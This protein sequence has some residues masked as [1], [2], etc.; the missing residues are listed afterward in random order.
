MIE[1]IS[2]QH[3]PGL[4]Q[5]NLKRYVKLALDTGAS[6][7]AIVPTGQIVVDER[8]LMK[9]RFPLCSEY[10]ACMN[11]PPN[12][13]SIDEMRERIKLFE[14]VIVLKMD[15]SGE[16]VA[17]PAARDEGVEDLKSFVKLSAI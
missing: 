7:A 2:L 5:Q 12:T 3:D 10:G 11:C 8:V 9:C 15:V 14:Y 1:K 16:R 4:L 13:G 6:N 17:G